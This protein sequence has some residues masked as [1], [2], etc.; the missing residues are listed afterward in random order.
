MNLNASSV[1]ETETD[2]SV[3][4]NTVDSVK[5]NLWPLFK[6]RLKMVQELLDKVRWL[7]QLYACLHFY[8][9]AFSCLTW[10]PYGFKRIRQSRNSWPIF[11]LKISKLQLCK[12]YFKNPK[13]SIA[14][15]YFLFH[16]SEGKKCPEQ[17][18]QSHPWQGCLVARSKSKISNKQLRHVA[19]CSLLI[20]FKK[21]ETQI[22]N[23]GFQHSSKMLL[24]L[25]IPGSNF[26]NGNLWN[27]MC[28]NYSS[29]NEFGLFH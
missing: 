20:Q 24:T 12:K 23:T 21:L 7:E 6:I 28:N 4:Q 1:F 29:W 14:A 19:R 27:I 18:D 15:L 16:L 3:I 25:K 8:T 9:L 11:Q 10:A 2:C 13:S 5:D 22:K 17:L 26:S